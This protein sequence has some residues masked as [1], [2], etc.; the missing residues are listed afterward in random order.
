MIMEDPWVLSVFGCMRQLRLFLLILASISACGRQA[1]PASG[2]DA[3]YQ[4]CMRYGG[5]THGTCHATAM[6]QAGPPNEV[7]LDEAGWARL[8]EQLRATVGDEAAPVARLQDHGFMVSQQLD[9]EAGHCYRI[10]VA[11]AS[12]WPTRATIG[13]EQNRDGSWPNTHLAQRGFDLTRPVDSLDFCVENSGPALLT[14]TATEGGIMVS[15]ARLE[16]AMAMSRRVEAE[17]DRRARLQAEEA[18]A[19]RSEARM[20][21]NLRGADLRRGGDA[22]AGGCARCRVSFRD[23][24]ERTMDRD[25]T[26]TFETCAQALGTDDRGRV[27]CASP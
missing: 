3:A 20:E 16:Y 26:L 10:T 1:P 18:L 24:R 13:F 12:R 2:Y 11:W 22:F 6:H 19:A 9:V 25:C 4:R 7:V 21:A 27:L 5:S 15:N 23:C 8:E 14:L 17:P